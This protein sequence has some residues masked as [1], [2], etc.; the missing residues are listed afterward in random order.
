MSRNFGQ[1]IVF[2][3]VTASEL[4][5][6]YVDAERHSAA[7]GGA[8]ADI[9]PEVGAPFRIFGED[10]VSGINLAV[11][12][13]TLVVQRWRGQA[14]AADDGDSIL[15]LHFEDGKAGGAITLFQANVPDEASALVNPE[16]WT[17]LYWDRWKAYFARRRN[18]Q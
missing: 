16:A 15:I 9:S 10:A 5:H 13:A 14:W 17:A 7:L 1:H 4:F 6:T 12:P 3:G 18:L 8:M 2:E 11:D